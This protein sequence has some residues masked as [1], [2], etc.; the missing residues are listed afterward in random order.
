MEHLLSRP[1]PVKF[2]QAPDKSLCVN[3]FLF[4]TFPC[5][6]E[7][8]GFESRFPLQHFQCFPDISPRMKSP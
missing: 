8:R 2:W 3:T 5:Q 4:I 1:Y 6:G 7:G